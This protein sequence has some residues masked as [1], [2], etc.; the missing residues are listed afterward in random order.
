MTNSTYI[1]ATIDRDDTKIQQ[2]LVAD[3]PPTAKSAANGATAPMALGANGSLRLDGNGTT[4]G[5]GGRGVDR[6]GGALVLPAP[7]VGTA[8][9]GRGNGGRRN[10]RRAGVRL[11]GQW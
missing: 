2:H 3:A 4:E 7:V 6:T 5:G 9:L 1:A 10:Q 8:D 11:V